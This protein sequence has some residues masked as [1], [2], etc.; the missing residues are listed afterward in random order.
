M[1][2]ELGHMARHADADFTN[3][4]TRKIVSLQRLVGHYMEKYLVKPAVR[5][6]NWEVQPLSSDQLG[7]TC[8]VSHFRVAGLRADATIRCGQ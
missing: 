3:T 2:A 6:S 5:T 1:C 7:C 4:F 8:S